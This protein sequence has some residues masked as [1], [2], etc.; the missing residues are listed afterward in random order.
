M[1]TIWEKEEESQY[2]NDND[3]SDPYAQK[4]R[5]EEDRGVKEENKEKREEVE[6]Q[7]SV[8]SFS[9]D[10]STFT[11]QLIS[12]LHLEMFENTYQSSSKDSQRYIENLVCRL[13]KPSAPFLVVAGDAGYPKH[14]GLFEAFFDYIRYM[15]EAVFFVMGNHEYYHDGSADGWSITMDQKEERAEQVFRPFTN[16]YILSEKRGEILIDSLGICV[17]GATLWSKCSKIAASCIRDYEKIWTEPYQRL[18]VDDTNRLHRHQRQYLVEKIQSYR[19]RG[20]SLLVVTHHLPTYS[21]VPSR[22]R[23]WEELN[24]AFA[25]SLFEEE[26]LT[27]Q[28]QQQQQITDTDSYGDERTQDRSA[29]CVWLTGHSHGTKTFSIGDWIFGLNAF[30]Y[31]GE[32]KRDYDRARLFH[33][34]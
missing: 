1:D 30:G 34:K 17:V 33:L 12:D 9:T 23:N 10:Q 26:L 29:P 15:F 25:T 27:T 4:E 13:I 20:Y 19:K 18:T 2:E 3:R 22:F 6:T 28:Q 5:E 8:R 21:L 31:N 11:V 16:V 24:S 14:G 32:N 7:N